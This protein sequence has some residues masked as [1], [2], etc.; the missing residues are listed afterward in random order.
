MQLNCAIPPV[1]GLLATAGR[2]AAHLLGLALVLTLAVMPIAKAGGSG[3]VALLLAAEDYANTNRSLV[4]VRTGQEIARLLSARGFD[5][6]ERANPGN[7]SARAALGEFLAKANGAEVAVAILIGHGLSSGGQTFFLPTNASIERSTDLLSQGLSVANIIRLAS[8]AK[9]AGVCFLMTRPNFARPIDEVDLRPQFDLDVPANAFLALSSSNR[10]PLS[11]TDAMAS[12]SADAVVAL[13]QHSPHAKLQDLLSACTLDQQG[14]LIGKV[15]E[16]D[17]AA[18]TAHIALTEAPAPP[19]FSGQLAPAELASNNQAA[20]GEA[21]TPNPKD[22]APTAGSPAVLAVRQAA[23]ATAAPIPMAFDVAV[24]NAVA[25]LM[26]KLPPSEL[27]GTPRNIAIDPLIDGYSGEQNAATTK[28]GGMIASL[29]KEAHKGFAIVPF[30]SAEVARRPLVLIGT[31][32][33]VNS[34]N[35]AD[36]PPDAFWICLAVIDLQ[37]GKIVSKANARAWRADVNTTP[38][39]FFLD[40]P[41]WLSDAAIV[42]YIKTC[43]TTR[44]GDQVNHE[45]ADRII[46]AA[47][48]SDAIDE[49][50]RKHYAEAAELWQSA[51]DLPGGNQLRVYNG[52]YLVNWHMHREAKAVEAFGALV[53]YGLKASTVG[54]MFLFRPNSTVFTEPDAGVAPY[55]MWLK[56]IAAR[57]AA[58]GTC[59]DIVGHTSV[60]GLAAIN[61]QLSIRRAEYV[62]NRLLE[63]GPSLEKRTIATGVGS[64]EAIVRTDWDGPHN[65][66]DR[67][68][69]FKTVKCGDKL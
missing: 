67:R 62:R 49:Y 20:T 39:Q 3:R 2:H 25:A 40:S 9:V 53:D 8:Q 46:A 35:Q 5:V 17:L 43:Q 10:S 16:F 18:P 33:A 6:V 42:S 37:T 44:I 56:V 50:N 14:T 31:L 23:P 68:V 29:V 55:G 30:T 57:T 21:D 66:I 36:G 7:A 65:A 15:T 32:A 47:V 19:P 59:L 52:L 64:K 4:G 51:L 58:A 28:T 1:R 63:Y 54:A 60:T 13:L 11:R 22:V 69:E 12:R 26:S 27:G 45:Y 48:T 41:I 61:D 34:K 38:T 24:K